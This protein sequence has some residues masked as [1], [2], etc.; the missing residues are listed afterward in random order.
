MQSWI[1]GSQSE[2]VK[3]EIYDSLIPYDRLLQWSE[4]SVVRILNDDSE[5][6]HGFPLVA[7]WASDDQVLLN[8][9][10]KRVNNGDFVAAF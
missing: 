8:Y 2:Q 10:I 5:Q 3:N 6:I 7:A 1:V 9:F 4:Q